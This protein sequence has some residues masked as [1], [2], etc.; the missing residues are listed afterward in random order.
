MWAA[1][2]LGSNFQI[3]PLLQDWQM[4]SLERSVIAMKLVNL[5]ATAT[6]AGALTGT[7]Y[8]DQQRAIRTAL[9]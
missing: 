1:I 3:D 7:L 4:A 6:T 2:P 5:A 9:R 8:L